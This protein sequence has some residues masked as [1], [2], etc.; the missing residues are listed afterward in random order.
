MVMRRG[1]AVLASGLLAATACMP[2]NSQGGSGP[3]ARV[4][5]GTVGFA[6]PAYEACWN[7]CFSMDAHAAIAQAHTAT[8]E[9]PTGDRLLVHFDRPPSRCSVTYEDQSGISVSIIAQLEKSDLTF[10]AD[11]APAAYLYRV[12]CRWSNGSAGYLLPTL[13]T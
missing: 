9:V 10:L 1:L 5:R 7:T 12:I 2:A 4:V 8:L 13:I 11:L 3:T 6:L